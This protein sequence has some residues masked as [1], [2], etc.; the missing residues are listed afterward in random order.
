MN[1]IVNFN[2]LLVHKPGKSSP[3]VMDLPPGNGWTLSSVRIALDIVSLF[4]ETVRNAVI[5]SGKQHQKVT[6]FNRKLVR[7]LKNIQIQHI[8]MKARFAT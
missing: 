6:G 8:N 2:I 3:K 7:I 4:T 1:T 5:A